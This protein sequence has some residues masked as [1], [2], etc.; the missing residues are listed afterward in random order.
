MARI[1]V[2]TH[3]F[4]KFLRRKFL[5]MRDSGYLLFGVLC[6]MERRGHSWK[7]YKGVPAR[8]EGDIA[9]L[10]LDCSVVPPDYIDFVRSFPRSINLAATDITKR[11]VSGALLR[12]A[13]VWDGP[14]I[15]KSNLNF[16]G[17]P[18]ANHNWRAKRRRKPF[19]HPQ[20]RVCKEYKV[21]DSV[22]GMPE[23]YW[24]STDLVVERFIPEIEPDG[25]A[26]RTWVFMGDKERSRRQVSHR[27]IVKAENI[28]RSEPVPVPEELRAERRR[29]G[30]DFGKFDFVVHD[31][32]GVLL[33]ANKTPGSPPS[34]IKLLAE[35][36]SNLADGLEEML[37]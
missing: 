1:V 29:L 18:E 32:R 5:V 16:Q 14:V 17:F 35:G 8:A 31:G 23:E 9:I 13:D 21:F 15:V 20:A 33:D 36:A 28:V 7:I 37:P 4:D 2:V 10:H 27:R 26:M 24:H 25:F 12:P 11:N 34:L 19:P 6:E 3:E 30:I 22:Q